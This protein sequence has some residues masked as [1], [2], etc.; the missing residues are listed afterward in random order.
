MRGHRR[1]TSDAQASAG[2]ADLPP[3]HDGGMDGERMAAGNETG[4]PR[5][6]AEIRRGLIKD[7]DRG[8]ETSINLQDEQAI[9]PR[10][11]IPKQ[12][13]LPGTT[14]RKTHS[15]GGEHEPPAA[16]VSGAASP[17]RD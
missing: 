4:K 9:R 7:S 11:E 12:S 16:R 17:R 13:P 2:K 15:A 3:D 14:A 8:K 6:D 1:E 5:S 10:S